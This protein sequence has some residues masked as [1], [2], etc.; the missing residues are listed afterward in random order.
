MDAIIPRVIDN[1][2]GRIDGPMAI[3]LAIQPIMATAFALRDGVRDSKQQ[4]APCGLSLYLDPDHRG[5]RLRD[6]WRSIRIVF[7]VALVLDV[8]YQ[9]LQL[10]WVY[11]GEALIV[12]Q[13]VALVPYVIVR[14]LANRV[15]RML[16]R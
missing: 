16:E 13:V 11:I 9:L 6:G 12:A 15:A 10:D 8:V 2:F 1:L 5:H 14:D 7:F 3:R 4:R